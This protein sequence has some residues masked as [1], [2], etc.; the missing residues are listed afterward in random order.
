MKKLTIIAALLF[1][2]ASFG[3]N[4]QSVTYAEDPSQGLLIN[5]FP[6]NWFIQVEGG[7]NVFMSPNDTKVKSFGDRITPSFQLSV[8]KWFSPV[9]GVRV[10]GDAFMVKGASDDLAVVRGDMALRPDLDYAKDGYVAQK[11]W[12]FGPNADAMLN[13][14]NWWCGYKP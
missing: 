11:A 3:A 8:G 6:N 4:A 13:L 5:N 2:A 12:F 7:A 14:T 9:F 10:T 1:S